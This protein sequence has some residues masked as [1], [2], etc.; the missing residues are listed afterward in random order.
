MMQI[1]RIHNNIMPNIQ[2]EDNKLRE[3]VGVS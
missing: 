3:V 2:C 1:Q